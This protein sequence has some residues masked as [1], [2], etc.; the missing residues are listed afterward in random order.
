MQVTFGEAYDEIARRSPR[1]AAWV[2]SWRR[3]YAPIVPAVEQFVHRTL[4]DVTS[5]DVI[6]TLKRG[7]H[8]LG[9]IRKESELREV[10]DITM[11]ATAIQ[12]LFHLFLE[13]NGALPTWAEFSAF[14][15]EPDQK[16]LLLDPW[17]RDLKPA[18][19][20]RGFRKKDE[21]RI[22][23]AIQWRLGRMY[24][25]NMREIDMLAR[26]RETYNLHLKYHV[27]ADVRLRTDF[28]VGNANV[29]V[30]LSNRTYRGEGQS[31]KNKAAQFLA[32]AAPAFV[33]LEV[34]FPNQRDFGNL[35]RISDEVMES[36]AGSIRAA[37]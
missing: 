36:L 28:W 23:E 21:P 19:Q 11:P 7:T 3:R 25:S 5:D 4:F 20:E 6:R 16:K 12:D 15:H 14:L 34:E 26:M 33:F 32:D 9:E 1:A 35:Y 37:M 24:Y 8:A 27:F 30:F 31:R 2:S 29:S 10:E 17:W 18:L 13:T 22:A